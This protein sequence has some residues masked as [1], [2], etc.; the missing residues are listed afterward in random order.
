MLAG[1]VRLLLAAKEQ[2]AEDWANVLALLE[3][4]EWVKLRAQTEVAARGM[5]LAVVRNAAEALQQAELA[6]DVEARGRLRSELRELIVA[7]RAKLAACLC[8]IDR[9]LDLMATICGG[10]LVAGP[11]GGCQSCSDRLFCQNRADF[12]GCRGSGADAP[13]VGV[14]EECRRPMHR[15]V[16]ACSVGN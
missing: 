6:V 9:E 1:N 4:R 12:K 8:A 11:R 2:V 3:P 13:T 5:N 7:E 16:A 10:A 15:S 14:A